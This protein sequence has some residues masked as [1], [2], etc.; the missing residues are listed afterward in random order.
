M[1]DKN[2]DVSLKTNF[3][4]EMI[5][6]FDHSRIPIDKFLIINMEFYLTDQ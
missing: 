2:I 5:S 1:L 6:N 3:T 4:K